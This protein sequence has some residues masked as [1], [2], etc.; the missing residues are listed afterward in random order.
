MFGTRNL[1]HFLNLG[2]TDVF[3]VINKK[4]NAFRLEIDGVI[5]FQEYAENLSSL[6]QVI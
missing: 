1:S 3:F 6:L 2:C 4:S 5:A